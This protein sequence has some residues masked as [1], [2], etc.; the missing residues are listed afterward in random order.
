MA[1][2]SF[3]GHDLKRVLFAAFVGFFGLPVGL[4][5]LVAHNHLLNAL[6]LLILVM[7]QVVAFSIYWSVRRQNRSS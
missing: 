7:S 3:R 6:G 2:S 1:V 5:G 4:L